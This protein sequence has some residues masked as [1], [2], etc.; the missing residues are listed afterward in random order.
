MTVATDDSPAGIAYRAMVTSEMAVRL[1]KQMAK[2][3]EGH[4]AAERRKLYLAKDHSRTL[5]R[6]N[7]ESGN[8][9]ERVI[10][11]DLEEKAAKLDG[12]SENELQDEEDAA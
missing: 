4:Y 10:A 12:W 1:V 5:F 11:S 9:E 8:M 7:A 3:I 6:R 2:M